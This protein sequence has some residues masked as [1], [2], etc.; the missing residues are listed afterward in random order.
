M[1][2]LKEVKYSG[3]HIADS[4]ILLIFAPSNFKSVLAMSDLQIQV[5]LTHEC[6][7]AGKKVFERVVSISD[8]VAV[9]FGGVVRVLRFLFGQKAIVSFNIF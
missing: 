6:K 4:D 9:D 3:N 8:S 1:G 2:K 7:S 5:F